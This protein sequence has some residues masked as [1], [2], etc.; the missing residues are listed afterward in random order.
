MIK[1]IYKY[2]IQIKELQTLKLPVGSKIL[3]LGN[4]VGNNVISLWAMVNSREPNYLPLEIAVVGTGNVVE[5]NFEDIYEY[6]DTV[7]MDN[8]FVW[9]VYANK[10][11][12]AKFK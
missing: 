7:I 8:Q 3:K 9:H 4:K 11:Q 10:E 5:Y 1:K 6:V 2:D 12:L